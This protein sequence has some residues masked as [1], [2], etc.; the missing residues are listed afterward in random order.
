MRASSL[1]Y[2]TQFVQL[3]KLLLGVFV[4]ALIAVM[5]LYPVLKKN[6]DVRV[7]FTSIE[8]TMKPP[9]TQM[10]NANFHGFDEH[11]QP[12]NIT[13]VSA[14]QQDENNVTFD[15]VNC[16]ITLSSGVW[17]TLQANKGSMKIKERLLTLQGSIE[18]F[19]DE[20]YELRTPYM[21][22]D[23]GKK[24][25]VT[26]D[27]VE[28]QGPLGTLKAH[29]AVFYGNTK[30]IVFGGPVLVTLYLAPKSS[31]TQEKKEGR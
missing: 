4:V 14:V 7:A 12:Y 6:K 9:P 28:G 17:L 26:H 16:D 10:I 29:G 20:G 31:S 21:E 3:A 15:K 1:A 13:A 30:D 5:F 18:M 23:I 8:K 22:V 2:Y 24:M 25:A 11:D 27:P 19:D